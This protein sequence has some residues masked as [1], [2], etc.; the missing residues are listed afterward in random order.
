MAGSMSTQRVA[1]SVTVYRNVQSQETVGSGTETRTVTVTRRVEEVVTRWIEVELPEAVTPEQERVLRELV[2]DNLSHQDD[3]TLSFDA[4]GF[5]EQVEGAP[6]LRGLTITGSSVASLDRAL[7]RIEPSAAYDVED[8]YVPSARPTLGSAELIAEAD[9]YDDAASCIDVAYQEA[10]QAIDAGSS[11]EVVFLRDEDGTDHVEFVATGEPPPA[12]Y[13]ELARISAEDYARIMSEHEGRARIRELAQLVGPEAAQAIESSLFADSEDQQLA[14]E[15]ASGVMTGGIVDASERLDREL[16]SRTPEDRAALMNALL[17]HTPEAVGLLLG[18]VGLHDQ[19]PLIAETFGQVYE[20]RAAHDPAGTAAMLQTVLNAPERLSSLGSYGAGGVEH[21]G[22]AIALS[23]SSQLQ[24]AAVEMFL[25]EAAQL[26]DLTMRAGPASPYGAEARAA[27]NAAIAAAAGLDTPMGRSLSMIGAG[28]VQTDFGFSLAD[29]RLSFLDAEGWVQLEATLSRGSV[30]IDES[31]QHIDTLQ[32]YWGYDNQTMVSALREIYYPT[33]LDPFLADAGLIG[34][35]IHD[36]GVYPADANGISASDAALS[37]AILFLSRQGKGYVSP[38]VDIL[39]GARHGQFPAEF[40][41]DHVIAGLDG[42]FHP[43]TGVNVPLYDIALRFAGTDPNL[44]TAMNAVTWLGDLGAVVGIAIKSG[45]TLSERTARGYGIE[46]PFED[47][48]GDMMA[49]VITGAGIDPRG[50]D[51]AGS[52]SAAFDPNGPA[53]QNRYETFARGIGLTID[54]QTGQI[55]NPQAFIDRWQS[56][57]MALGRGLG[58]DLQNSEAPQLARMALEM[59]LAQLQR[60]LD[61]N[62]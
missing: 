10:E 8:G 47:L 57:V 61:A 36:L 13:K 31:L 34:S 45:G 12:G 41:L 7:E 15:L 30:T 35:E 19:H 29:L 18:F 3:G 27:G 43:Q 32:T 40:G 33:L 39:P 25:E 54:P 21:V 38:M 51:L 60:E 55:T 17:E 58:G 48:N 46:M 6:E 62:R 26:S 53:W 9:L 42:A 4:Q 28:F 44:I 20:T 56:S 52:L 49:F 1:V 22:R 37:E 16:A 11:G 24:K 23:G 2:E 59:F 50:G 5:L 14:A